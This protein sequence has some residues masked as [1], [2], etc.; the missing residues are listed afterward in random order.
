MK[1]AILFLFVMI[2][3]LL[4]V[5]NF[6]LYPLIASVFDYYPGI[7]SIIVGIFVFLIALIL[8]CVM[9]KSSFIRRSVCIPLFLSLLVS[10]IFTLRFGTNQYNN[11]FLEYSNDLYDN[12]GLR[13]ISKGGE[14]YYKAVLDGKDYIAAY[15]C[16]DD[17][18]YYKE[19]SDSRDIYTIKFYNANDYSFVF[20][21][22]EYGYDDNDWRA[23]EI[24]EY[25]SDAT[26]YERIGY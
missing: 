3:V 22:V 21:K 10:G 23:E 7:V 16:K 11:G 19:Y 13:V 6:F 15:K 17:Y 5:I 8:S 2:A 26:I 14:L 24:I 4:V 20:E 12:W 18:K 25:Y 1:N 9:T